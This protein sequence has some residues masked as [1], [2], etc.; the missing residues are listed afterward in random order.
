MRVGQR[1]SSA[2]TILSSSASLLIITSQ[3]YWVQLLREHLA[4]ECRQE[5]AL[6]TEQDAATEAAVLFIPET[7]KD[8]GVMEVQAVSC[9]LPVLMLLPEEGSRIQPQCRTVQRS[10]LL[11]EL[12]KEIQQL[13]QQPRR[14]YWRELGSFDP[15]DMRLANLAETRLAL[16]EKEAAI[17]M[18]LHQHPQGI[19]RDRLLDSIWRYHPDVETHTLETHLYRLRQKIQEVFGEKLQISHDEITGYR[20]CFRGEERN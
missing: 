1:S 20:L 4:V 8:V 10:L 19:I 2:V 14:I 11:A 5:L 9:Q 17:L 16:T 3:P 18:A 15:R 13:L 6:P 7:A 12:K